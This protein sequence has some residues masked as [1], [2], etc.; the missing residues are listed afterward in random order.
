M[1]SADNRLQQVPAGSAQSRWVSQLGIL[2]SAAHG[3][4]TVRASWEEELDGLPPNAR[5]GSPSYDT[6]TAERDAAA[7]PLLELWSLHGQAV[8]DIRAA[9]GPSRPR[10]QT[11]APAPPVT[12]TSS[13]PAA[14]R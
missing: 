3:L 4:D 5:P 2:T 9:A 12:S 13:T 11:T 6:A 1:T 10:L 7:W 8:L 14:R